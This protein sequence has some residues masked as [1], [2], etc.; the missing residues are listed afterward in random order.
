MR[1]AA[2]LVASLASL[3]SL[4]S[5]APLALLVL[6]A[7]AFAQQAYPPYGQAPQQAPYPQQ[8]PGYGPPPVQAAPYGQ[9]APY[10]AP[11]YGAPQYGAP[12]AYGPQNS[13]N[14]QLQNAERSD[15]GRG[16]EVAYVQASVGAGFVG[17]DTLSSSNLGLNKT[18]EG[19]PVVGLGAGL[20]LLF[21]TIGARARVTALSELDFWQLDLEAGY[22][23]PIG[24][25]DPY[26]AVHG[27][28]AF[29]SN[30][31]SGLVQPPDGG[32]AVEGNAASQV[33]LHGAEVGVSGGVDYYVTPLISVGADATAE[34]LFLSRPKQ[35]P[36]DGGIQDG[37]SPAL[38]L[39]SGSST[40]LGLS[41]SLHAGLHFGS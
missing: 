27:G 1:A 22:H 4:V 40:G 31:S 26:V 5:L 28:Y 7:N 37:P 29:A 18:S 25:W 32:G 14:A 13:T 36:T 33:A 12:S 30:A 38:Y 23:V 2:R 19:G 39:T 17:L 41:A 6:E 8:Q 20:R 9:P 21:F 11:T 16:L 24:R 35:T 10:G 15:S 34:V 3:A